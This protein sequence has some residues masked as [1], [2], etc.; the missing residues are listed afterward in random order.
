MNK[1]AIKFTILLLVL[2]A[3]APYTAN[4]QTLENLALALNP[5]FPKSGEEV[6]AEAILT[7]ADPALASFE[8][9][10]DGKLDKTSS[11]KGKNT[12][13]LRLENE[14][15]IVIDLVVTT[16]GGNRLSA[17]RAITKEKPILIW[18]ADTSVPPG[19]KGKA[20]PSPGSTVTVM[21][22]PGAGF[23]EPAS[24]LLYSWNINVEPYPGIS[25]VGKNSFT[26]KTSLVP[27][28]SQQIVVK[29][30]NTS[31]TIIQETTLILPTHNTELLVYKLAPAGLMDF[32]NA[33]SAFEGDAGIISDLIAVPFYFR[34]DQLAA[35]NF[36]WSV[37]GQAIP[38]GDKPNILSLKTNTGETSENSISVNASSGSRLEKQEASYL[39]SANFR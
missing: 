9:Y 7:G 8:W 10:K 35:L 34:Q 1:L 26:L 14:A 36:V 27:G 12:F 3:L 11:G 5:P 22:I 17:T 33:V 30:S 19:Y 2:T 39:F 31:K 32:S 23:G 28:V 13:N 16:P 21:A 37:G 4:T 15:R 18:W 24:S 25:G 29:I 6:R 20:L 38:G